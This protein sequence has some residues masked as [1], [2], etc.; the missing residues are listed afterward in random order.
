MWQSPLRELFRADIA[1][2]VR[3]Y[4]LFTYLMDDVRREGKMS[5]TAIDMEHHD[6]V[7]WGIFAMEI[8]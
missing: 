5:C 3:K 8:P 4:V 6:V 1:R 7:R 2:V